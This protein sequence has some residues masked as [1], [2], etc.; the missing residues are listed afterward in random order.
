MSDNSLQNAD[1]LFELG[2]LH[3]RGD[4]VPVNPSAAVG[5][6]TDALNMGHRKAAECLGEA[7]YLGLGTTKDEL[8]AEEYF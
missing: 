4:G 5:Y 1:Q 6:F 2:L 3:M 8:K 7:C